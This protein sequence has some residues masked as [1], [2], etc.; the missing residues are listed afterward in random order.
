MQQSGS[1]LCMS[2]AVLHMTL[3]LLV[4]VSASRSIARHETPLHSRLPPLVAYIYVSGDL[5]QGQNPWITASLNI[6]RIFNP[7]L[8]IYAIT[9][10]EVLQNS[11]TVKI[12]LEQRVNLR[13]A[14]PYLKN[15]S[16]AHQYKVNRDRANA[17]HPLI[18]LAQ[19][20]CL[21]ADM[22][23][24]QG[25]QRV[26][27]LDADQ[28]LFT[29]VHSRHLF[30]HTMQYDVVAPTERCAQMVLWNSLE[31]LDSFCDF[32]VGV[33]LGDGKL[34]E[35][36]LWVGPTWKDQSDMEALDVFIQHECPGKGLKCHVMSQLATNENITAKWDVRYNVMFSL[37]WLFQDGTTH[38]PLCEMKAFDEYIE[39]SR[40]HNNL[41]VPVFKPT[42]TT[43]SVL[44]FQG[45]C[46]Q[47]VLVPI[48]VKYFSGL[49]I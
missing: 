6:T 20:F 22:A 36:H 43:L 28:T 5:L 45:T 10:E 17:T 27:T 15:G 41:P 11:S 7:T 3:L 35:G 42:M 40:D 30:P 29:N 34:W 31:A 9:T 47:A 2:C 49:I 25:H 4:A 16:R 1:R 26:L 38:T 8:P 46:K 48:Y 24:V 39:W 37:Y 21:Y 23:K 44:H 19:R 32:L 12:L 18:S 33:W 13:L 14:E